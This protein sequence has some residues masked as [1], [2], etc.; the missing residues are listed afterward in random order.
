ME[1]MPGT[2][3]DKPSLP[4]DKYALASQPISND[5]LHTDSSGLIEGVV[6]IPASGC[7]IA[8]YRAMPEDNRSYP[9]I[10]VIHEIFGVHEYIKDVCRRLAKLGYYAIAPDL[11]SRQGNVQSI[12]NIETLIEIALSAPDAQIMDDLDSTLSWVASETRADAQRVGVTGFCWGGRLVWMYASHNPRVKA[13]VSWYGILKD[14]K[15]VL[16]PMNPIDII[17]N[18]EVPVLGLYGAT[19]EYIPLDSINDVV[20]D[21]RKY[22]KH[23]DIV[24]YP[25]IAHGF[26][27]DYRPSYSQSEALDGWERMKNWFASNLL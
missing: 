12:D 10:I 4:S 18:L 26:H 5:F 8:A 3:F 23:S 7:S 14:E 15:T 1:F 27:A 11:L 19:D 13:G 2:S 9:V 22:T 16:R 6:D 17:P 24:I 20:F 25:N 21:L